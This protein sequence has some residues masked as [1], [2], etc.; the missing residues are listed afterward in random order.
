MVVTAVGQSLD[1]PTIANLSASALIERVLQLRTKRREVRDALVNLGNVAPCY[2]VNLR[3][4]LVWL[5]AQ[6]QQLAYGIHFEAKLSRM[7][8]EFEPGSVAG[9]V[10][11]LAPLCTGWQ[12]QQAYLLIVA[13]RRHL[14]LGPPRQFANRKFHRTAS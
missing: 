11:S 12:W 10:A 8:D 14:D 5:G 1:H 6:S 2:F 9:V 4:G 3:T 7:T 13:D